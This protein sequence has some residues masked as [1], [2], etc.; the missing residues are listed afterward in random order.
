V[1]LNNVLTSIF[2]AALSVLTFLPHHVQEMVLDSLGNVVSNCSMLLLWKIGTLN[3]FGGIISALVFIGVCYY[4]IKEN[5]NKF[6]AK[7]PDFVDTTQKLAQDMPADINVDKYHLHRDDTHA[8]TGAVEG[9]LVNSRFHSKMKGLGSKAPAAVHH[10]HGH[11]HGHHNRV[12]PL[13]DAADSRGS[14]KLK[15]PAASHRTVPSTGV[16]PVAKSSSPS[17]SPGAIAMGAPVTESVADALLQ[18]EKNLTNSFQDMIAKQL[19]S[20]NKR[21]KNSGKSADD[22]DGFGSDQNEDRPDGVGSNRNR[23]RKAAKRSKSRSSRFEEDKNDSDNDNIDDNDADNID[24]AIV[25][26]SKNK[27][28]TKYLVTGNDSSAKFS[29]QRQPQGTNSVQGPGAV[30]TD[31]NDNP[32]SLID[33]MSATITESDSHLLQHD[34]SLNF[35]AKFGGSADNDAHV[36]MNEWEQNNAAASG[37]G[38]VLNRAKRDPAASASSNPSVTPGL[39]R[40]GALGATGKPNNP[41]KSGATTGATTISKARQSAEPH[42]PTWH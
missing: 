11:G 31:A 26:K 21:S 7:S 12:Q 25:R 17:G 42:F 24:R 23:H 30:A 4:I 35:F 6:A 22:F 39:L 20:V 2:V 41:N 34:N 29:P 15:A 3:V 18:I 27:S 14:G 13:D 1:H 38:S 33:I 5:R 40:P 8:G 28:Q 16:E 36:N 9:D 19:Q 32:R 10:H 37:P